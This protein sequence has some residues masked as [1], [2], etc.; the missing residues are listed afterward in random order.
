[1]IKQ[2]KEQL[3]SIFF[4]QELNGT[5]GTKLREDITN[6]P[7]LQANLNNLEQLDQSLQK[8]LEKIPL[9]NDFNQKLMAKLS[10]E[11]IYRPR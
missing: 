8:T 9:S 11:K 7:A 5:D 10:Q 2:S 1:M 4:D 3:L 6:D